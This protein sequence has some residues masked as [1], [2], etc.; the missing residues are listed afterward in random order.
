MTVQTI[1]LT[2]TL[3]MDSFAWTSNGLVYSR[4]LEVKLWH[5]TELVYFATAPHKFTVEIYDCE[6]DMEPPSDWIV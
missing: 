3:E 6:K 2:E 4:E 1:G 5:N